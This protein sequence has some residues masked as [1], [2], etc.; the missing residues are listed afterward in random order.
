MKKTLF[1]GK[2]FLLCFCTCLMGAIMIITFV[3]K[4]LLSGQEKQ[5]KLLIEKV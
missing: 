3:V 2:V 1:A 4:V 5:K